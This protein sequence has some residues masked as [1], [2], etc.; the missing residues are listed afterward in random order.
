MTFRSSGEESWVARLRLKIRARYL[1]GLIGVIAAL[2]LAVYGAASGG[3]D[4][5]EDYGA[6]I[7]V[8]AGPSQP[9]DKAGE[10]KAS[11]EEDHSNHFGG[12]SR[13]A[14][15]DASVPTSAMSAQTYSASGVDLTFSVGPIDKSGD[16]EGIVAGQLATARI[17]LKDKKTGK[18]FTPEQRPAL[19]VDLEKKA[20]GDQASKPLTCAEKIKLFAQGIVSYRPDFD[21]NSYYVLAMNQDATIS[22]ID[23]LVGVNGISQ[24][25]GM[26]FLNKPADDWALTGDNKKLFVSM[27]EANEVAVAEMQGFKVKKNIEVEEN[28]RRIAFQPGEKYLWVANDS[29][30]G[31]KSGVTVIDTEKLK[32][33][34]HIP[35]G[36]GNHEIAFSDDGAYAL[37][38]NDKEGTVSVIS[39]RSLKK[40]ADIKTGTSPRAVAFSAATGSAY[41]ADG[42]DGTIT[43]VNPASGKAAKRATLDA[44]IQDFRLTYDGK[45]GFVLDTKESRLHIYDVD[46]RKITSSLKVTENPDQMAVTWTYL[47]IR[48]KSKPE[49]SIID[50]AKLGES[51]KPDVLN[52]IAG[53]NAPD[54]AKVAS[55]TASAFF[56]VHGHGNHVVIANPADNYV[57]MYMEGMQAPMGGFANYYRKS[58]RAVTILDRSIQET[59]PGSYEGKV[60]VDKEGTYQA[61][62]L[63]DSPRIV[64]CFT[65]TAKPDPKA[66][67]GDLAK[68]VGVELMT[69]TRE[70]QVGEELDF[71][72]KL[73]D[74]ESG[75]PLAGKWKVGV[76][77]TAVSG[78][79]QDRYEAES[80]GKGLYRVKVTYRDPGLYRLF[81]AVPSLRVSF[82][83]LP[84]ALLKVTAADEPPS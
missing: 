68:T 36:R 60:P 4:R 45:W 9:P 62:V 67:Q 71:E 38:T 69:K 40:R 33:V 7:V 12:P 78:Q 72:F 50:L 23:P 27:P 10:E 21:M 49:V 63:L 73:F 22:V 18:P 82:D 76:I 64:R 44:T 58:P 54:A 11:E 24:I 28:P 16:Q 79:S 2:V 66:L 81:F 35:T 47:F 17:Q 29:A 42:D 70:L 80:L 46:A 25:Y 59:G 39:T 20:K 52:I 6:D 5:A 15:A 30:N 75:D 51:E 13:Y 56:P 43:A 26:V 14:S 48:S 32:R 77:S 61:A 31:R 41:V 8:T 65:F 1:V 3:A 55:T 34:A 53:Q 19:W 83:Q 84:P 57:Y 74:V 37:V